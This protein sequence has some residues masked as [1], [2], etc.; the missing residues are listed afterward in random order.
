MLMH[1]IK[2]QLSNNTLVKSL[3]WLAGGEFIQ[4]LIRLGAVV[5][6]ARAFTA[7]DYGVFAILL[8]LN[9]FCNILIHKGGVATKLI[10]A[11]QKDLESLANTAYWLNW[12]ICIPIFLIYCIAAALISWHSKDPNLFLPLC[13]VSLP[14]LI[15]PFY[16][17]QDALIQRENRMKVIAFAG[18]LYSFISNFSVIGFALLGMGIWSIVLSQ[19]LSQASWFIVYRRNQPWRPKGPFTLNGWR[20]IVHFAKYP[21]SVEFLN[22]LRANLD[23]ILVGSFLGVE[24]LGTYFFAFSAGLGLSLSAIGMISTSLYPYLCKVRSNESL[25]RSYYFKSLITISTVMVPLILLQSSLAYFYVPIV[26]GQKWVIAIPIIVMICLS[27]LPRPFALA[28][29]QLLI[30]VDKGNLS[31]LWN[32]IFTVIFSIVLLVAVQFNIFVVAACV[33]AVH[34]IGL[35]LFTVWATRLVFSRPLTPHIGE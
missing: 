9:E 22:K 27:G 31:L 21:L 26:F 11:D 19:V 29:E 5:V 28:A 8:T 10:H 34:L 4:R 18:T 13:I 30:I 24:Q 6:L 3:G 16:A 7:Q 25:F 20:E 23:Y 2:N 12:L 35:P 17:V 33:L 1:K 15:V 14:Y 32:L